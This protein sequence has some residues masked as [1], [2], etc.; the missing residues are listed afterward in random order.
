MHAVSGIRTH[1]PGFRESEDR[2][3]SVTDHGLIAFMKFGEVH[4][5]SFSL[6]IA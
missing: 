3:A 4:F 5:T 1:D 2:S 6:I